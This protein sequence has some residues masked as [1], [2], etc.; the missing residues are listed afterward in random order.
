M[1]LLAEWTIVGVVTEA[2]ELTSDKNKSWRAYVAKV[3]SFGAT[4]EIQLSHDQF[5]RIGEGQMIKAVGG[6][7]DQA[8]RTKF[9][10]KTITEQDGKGGAR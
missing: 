3:A 10:T 7:E 2:R 5:K 9:I 8:G 6:F 1:Q 4:F